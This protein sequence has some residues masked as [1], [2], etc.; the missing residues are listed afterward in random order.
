MRDDLECVR[1]LC[2]REIVLETVPQLEHV[3][4]QPADGKHGHDH[5]NHL[6][7][8]ATT[9]AGR[10]GTAEGKLRDGRRRGIGHWTVR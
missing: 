10:Q 6:G 2:L 5:G 3:Y 1:R 8:L 7:R 4:W 9:P